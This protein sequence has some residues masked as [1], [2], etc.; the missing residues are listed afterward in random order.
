MDTVLARLPAPS[1]TRNDIIAQH[2]TRVIHQ[3]AGRINV[4]I[5]LVVCPKV[6]VKSL[7]PPSLTAL[8]TFRRSFGV[9]PV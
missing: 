1:P 9:W 5:R 8:P 3:C 2:P 7:T 4:W 6:K